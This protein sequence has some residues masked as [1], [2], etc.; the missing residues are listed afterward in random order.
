MG[1]YLALIFGL[2]LLEGIAAIMP[3]NQDLPF[4]PPSI[5]PMI[6]I[7]ALGLL[8]FGGM[9]ASILPARKAAS[10]NPIEA[11]RTE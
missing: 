9:I 2:M 8:V 6:A 1:G 4:D 11:I 5:N 7:G 10:I 3:K